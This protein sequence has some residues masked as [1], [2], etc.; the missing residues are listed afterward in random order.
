MMHDENSRNRSFRRPA[1]E[2]DGNLGCV[3]QG[4]SWSDDRVKRIRRDF[5]ILE[6]RVH[7]HALVYLDNG[8]TTQVPNQVVKAIT[9]HYQHDNANVHRGIH[10][11]S[12][13]STIALE[14]ARERVSAFVHASSEDEIIF[15]KG[16]TD[17]LNTVARMIEPSISPDETVV[18]TAL[19]HH[20]NFVPWQQLCAR[21]GARFEVV[22][23][24]ACG[25]VDLDAFEQ[26]L[27]SQHVAVAAFAHVSNVLGTVNPV[28]RMTQLAH[29]YGALAVVDAAQSIR[30]ELVDVAEIGCDFL[31]F[32]GH[33]MCAPTGIGV[34]Y[35]R[36]ELLD[37]FEPVEFGGEMVD[38]VTRASTSFEQPP[39]KFE[40]GTPNYVGAV[41]LAAAIDYL[42]DMDRGDIGSREHDLLDHALCG[43]DT[44]EGLHVL[45]S[46]LRRG[47]CLSFTVDD[48]HPYDLATL[49]DTQ[50]VALRSGN[51]CAQPLLHETLGVNNVTR[52]SPA[53]YNT[54]D[55]IDTCIEKLQRVIPLLRASR[56]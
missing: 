30:H 52:L 12:E 40:A 47:G 2:R 21:K 18:V 4:L 17:S 48:V 11:L 20:A 53:F 1:A 9:Q 10:S 7:G 25:D 34:L 13:R 27:A 5:P 39:L 33:K 26:V 19:E 43:L 32:S 44:V 49:M 54:F 24:D 23:L 50:G 41:A 55:E 46:P 38:K 8:A 37:R 56:R 31:A 14:R 15:T 35:G 6:E 36:W 22:P 3:G 29:A 45:G 51:Q 28:S 42:I 16:T